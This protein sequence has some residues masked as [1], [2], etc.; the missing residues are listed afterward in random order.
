VRRFKPIAVEEEIINRILET[1]TYAPSAHNRQPWRFA[2]ITQTQIKNRL[3][4]FLSDAFYQ[5]LLAD[6]LD[7]VEIETRLNRSKN[8]INQAPLII[9]LSMDMSEMDVYPDEKRANA[10]RI[11]A[12][13]ST[14]TAGLQLQLAAHAEGLASVWT[15]APLFSPNAVKMA[16]DLPK[17]WEPQA[18]FFV[19]YPDK[20]PNPKELK[21]LKNVILYAK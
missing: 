5:D 1:A 21:P 9:L 6:N 17:N 16:L 12:I 13:Q 4:E 20:E 19:G 10:E 3:Y 15:C 18:M 8:R 7:A 11:M 14:A 2:V